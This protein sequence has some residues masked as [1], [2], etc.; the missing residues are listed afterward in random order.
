MKEYKD[1][2]DNNILL[3]CHVA[4]YDS[5]HAMVC[6]GVVIRFTPRKVEVKPLGKNGYPGLR[7]PNVLLVIKS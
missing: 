1:S 5:W 4:F 7:Y 2:E 3:G 6:R